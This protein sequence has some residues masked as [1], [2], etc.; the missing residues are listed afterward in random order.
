MCMCVSVRMC[1]CELDKLS[2][3][4]YLYWKL[5]LKECWHFYLIQL[6]SASVDIETNFNKIIYL[7]VNIKVNQP[8]FA[9]SLKL[10]TKI[11]E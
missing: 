4:Y 10:Y 7:T 5:A 2:Y 3:C 1:V 6:H 11:N 8:M 9:R